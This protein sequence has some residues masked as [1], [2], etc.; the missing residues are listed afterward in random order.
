MARRISYLL[1]FA[2]FLS[3]ASAGPRTANPLNRL[4]A[5]LNSIF[6]NRDFAGAQWRVK[7]SSLRKA[8][9]LY[10]KNSSQLCIPASNNK[11]IT[12][13]VALL[14]LGPEY[15]FK[16]RILADGRI[17]GGVLQGNLIIVGSG[18]PSNAPIYQTGDPFFVFR[19]WAGKLKEQNIKAI[20]G[21]II[22][23]SG[24]F[25]EI[26]Y[27]HGWEWND[28]IRG[29]AAPVS[30]LQFN[31]NLV[32][33]RITPGYKKGESASI[34]ASPL[35]DYLTLNNKVLTEEENAP[36]AIRVE[37]SGFNELVLLRG[38]IHLKD[39]GISQ[40]VSVQFPARYYLSALRRVLSEEGIDL[41]KAEIR[42]TRNFT[43]PSSSLLWVHH[44]ASLAEIMKPILKESSNLGAET[45]A[46]TLGMELRGEG[47]FSKGREIIEEEL[48]K[49]GVD[50]KSYIYADASGL[51]RLNLVSADTLVQILKF[52][53]QDQRFSF[54]YDAM[55][56]AGCDGTL[57]NRMKGTAA[58]NN[59]HAK[60]GSMSNVSAISGYVQT[61]DR[62]M[63]AFSMM[64]DN[65][66]ASKS[67]TEAAQDAA[68]E[69]LA[70]FSRK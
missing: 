30:A 25:E 14:R 10:E 5:D 26:P 20:F 17:E 65:C 19:D 9:I 48:G 28:L 36:Q 68:I 12:A 40:N 38:S 61:K 6:L 1:V 58:E 3:G 57:A 21:E 64:I 16:T 4:R 2:L 46:R 32:S 70:K 13:A 45:L 37:R 15:Q 56:I 27:G 60:T 42:E 11:I 18:D 23:D 22:G 62:E 39:S 43:S 67:R 52:I 44:S 29:Y 50:K 34:E 33:L 49:I 51:S 63:L 59:A 53:H 54:F 69:R 31:E 8:D 7:V 41:S 55:P 35:P 47:T 66:L 24:A